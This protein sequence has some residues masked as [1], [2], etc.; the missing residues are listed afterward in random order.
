MFAI[1]IELLEKDESLLPGMT[2]SNQIIIE[3][4]PEQLIIPRKCLFSDSLRR[5]V[6]LKK[7]GRIW[8]N[9]WK[10]VLKMMTS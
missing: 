9:P 5:Y 8:E 2:S 10:R 3:K 7:D 6:Y 1:T 4:I